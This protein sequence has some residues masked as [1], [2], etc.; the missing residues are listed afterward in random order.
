VKSV[1]NKKAQNMSLELSNKQNNIGQ[2]PIGIVVKYISTTFIHFGQ[3]KIID[4]K[5][6]SS[7]NLFLS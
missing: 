5:Q 6:K 3:C 2:Y 7:Q 1:G 4:Q